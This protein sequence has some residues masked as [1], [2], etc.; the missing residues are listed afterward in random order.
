MKTKCDVYQNGFW[1]GIK[2]ALFVLGGALVLLLLNDILFC[3]CSYIVLVVFHNSEGI[4]LLP[5]LMCGLWT[6]YTDRIIRIGIFA[7]ILS[8]KHFFSYQA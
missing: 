1:N 2:T 8:I 4:S 6:N 5:N 7:C 3:I